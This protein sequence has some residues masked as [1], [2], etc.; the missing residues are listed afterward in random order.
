[1]T[2]TQL[3]IKLL[4]EEISALRSVISE[5]SERENLNNYIQWQKAEAI[6][7]LLNYIKRG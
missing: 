5:I 2:D 3:L 6:S 1:M 4:E 7:E